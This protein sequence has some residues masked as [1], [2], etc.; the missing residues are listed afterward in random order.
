MGDGDLDI[1]KQFNLYYLAF[2]GALSVEL[3]DLTLNILVE[4]K[5]R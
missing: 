3:L 1:Q 2:S 5:S 4:K